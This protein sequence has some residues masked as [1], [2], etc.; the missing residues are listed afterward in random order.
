MRM[1]QS[2]LRRI[3]VG[4]KWKKRIRYSKENGVRNIF[5]SEN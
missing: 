3:W 1:A 2:I 4:I 5:V